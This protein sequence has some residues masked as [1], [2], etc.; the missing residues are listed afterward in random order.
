MLNTGNI[1]DN[2][3]THRSELGRDVPN[4]VDEFFHLEKVGVLK[5]VYAGGADRLP[6]IVYDG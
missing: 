5:D 4:K 2:E 3:R 1:V 6:S